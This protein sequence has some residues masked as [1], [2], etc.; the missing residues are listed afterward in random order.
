VLNVV[1]LA[2][3][4]WIHCWGPQP[5]VVGAAALA[6]GQHWYASWLPVSTA[7]G[8]TSTTNLWNT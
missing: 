8:F 5:G 2:E 1:E 6:A 7:A 4:V 3:Q